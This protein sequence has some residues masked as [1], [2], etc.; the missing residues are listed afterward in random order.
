MV[1]TVA[2]MNANAEWRLT[3]RDDFAQ[4]SLSRTLNPAQ[5]VPPDRR[6][7]GRRAGAGLGVDRFG[8]DDRMAPSR[9]EFLRIQASM[10]RQASS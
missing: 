5:P 6:A 2:S 7:G 3:E 8:H 4:D 9:L 1:T 10:I